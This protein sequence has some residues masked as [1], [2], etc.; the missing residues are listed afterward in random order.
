MK[1]ETSLSHFQI[2]CLDH[3]AL[4]VRDL[5]VSRRWYEKVLGLKSYQKKEWGEVPIFLL[6]GTTG[7]A[8]FPADPTLEMPDPGLK[9]IKIDHFAFRL[10]QEDFVQARKRY[11]ELNIQY[12]FQDHH[13]FH[14]IYTRDPD[15][16]VVELT[17]LVVQAFEF[18]REGN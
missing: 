15:R 12:H 6:A 3:V 5:E 7:I 17:T 18:Y 1:E 11:E 16:H 9:H 8:L 2:E 13:Y 10:S 14:S 4:R